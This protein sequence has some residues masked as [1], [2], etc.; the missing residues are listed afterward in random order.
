[1]GDG[2]EQWWIRAGKSEMSETG[3]FWRGGRG[4]SGASGLERAERQENGVGEG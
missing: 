2:L 4:G 1:M 3:C